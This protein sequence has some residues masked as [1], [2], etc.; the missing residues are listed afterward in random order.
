M[1]STLLATAVAV[2]IG[3]TGF[4]AM[5]QDGVAAPESELAELR[6]QLAALQ[7]KVEELEERTEAQSGVNIDTAEA[8]D[9]MA[10]ASPKVETKGGLKVTSPDGK[11][12]A[13]LGGRIHFDTYAFDRD[14]ADVTGT[15]EFRRA[16]LTLQ[17]KALGWDYKMEQDF[18][19]GTTTGGIRDLF[20]SRKVARRNADHRPVQA[21]PLDG[22]ADQLQRGHDDGA[23][24]RLRHRLF[25]GRQFP[26]GRGLH[27]GRRQ[28]HLR[29]G[30]LQPAQHRRCPQRG[31]GLRRPRFTYAPINDEDGTFHLGVGSATRT[32]TGVRP[33]SRLRRL[34]RPPRSVA[35]H[36][37]DHRRQRRFR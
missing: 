32:R 17:G 15:T 31:H 30:G 2:A 34:C 7:A 12:E 33:T 14:D 3:G 5:A 23:P 27:D 35:D 16:R 13:S 25:G 1:R 20:I 9:R 6:A 36:R 10:K 37:H 24:V 8:L 22:G 28:L 21:L 26:A 11:F 4:T 19:D 18:A 29:R